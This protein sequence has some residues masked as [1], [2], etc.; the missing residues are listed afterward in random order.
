MI[1]LRASYVVL[2]HFEVLKVTQDTSVTGNIERYVLYFFLGPDAGTNYV[3]YRAI[4]DY[5]NIQTESKIFILAFD[6]FAKDNQLVSTNAPTVSSTPQLDI[7]IAYGYETISTETSDPNVAKVLSQ[8]SNKYG[9][10]IKGSSLDKVESLELRNGKINYKITYLNPLTH[11]SQKFIVYY[12][13]AINK[14]LIL[15]S[16]SLP[17]AQQFT[18][19]SDS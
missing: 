7:D 3:V 2:D 12:D 6:L 1:Y 14:V 10:L 8:I 11:A 16:V 15:N 4:V 13:P 9:P 19:L 17:S 5:D 18:Q